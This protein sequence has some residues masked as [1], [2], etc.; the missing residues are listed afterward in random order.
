MYSFH[1]LMLAKHC[2]KRGSDDSPRDPWLFA[3]PSRDLCA[4]PDERFSVVVNIVQH[5]VN[6]SIARAA[7][8]MRVSIKYATIRS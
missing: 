7:P 2:P 8:V 3:D 6:N 1:N 4:V 5:R